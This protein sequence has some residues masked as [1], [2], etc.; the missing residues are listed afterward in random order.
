MVP[1]GE[2]HNSAM[3]HLV[4]FP[5]YTDYVSWVF[6][7]KDVELVRQITT[8][9]A[10][11]PWAEWTP[12]LGFW[13]TYAIVWTF[14]WVGWMALLHERWIEV[15]RL[16]FAFAAT[17]T[18]QINYISPPPDA[19]KTVLRTKLKLFLLGWVLGLLVIFP[20]GL[21]YLFPWIPDPY[22]FASPPFIN[23]YFG[24]LIL[25]TISPINN[26]IPVW[27]AMSLN[28]MHFALF[29]LFPVK[30][31]F[32]I[33]F[34]DVFG[35]KLPS[36]VAYWLGY[37]P[38]GVRGVGAMSGPPFKWA[39]IQV[40]MF[41]GLIVIWF[42]LNIR[43][44]VSTIRL[45]RTPEDSKRALPNPVA[46]IVIAVS[47]I[48]L[49][50]MLGAAGSS[51]TSAILIM[52]VMLYTYLSSIR[53]L[54]YCGPVGT[55][56]MAIDNWPEFPMV[57]RWYYGPNVTLQTVNYEY[58][59]T[60]M[61]TNRFTSQLMSEAN[62]QFGMAFA[63]PLCYKVGFET[64]T[65]PMDLTKVILI[66]AIIS[67]VIG[68]PVGL[69]FD[70]TFGTARTPM[71]MYDAWWI[72]AFPTVGTLYGSPSPDPIIEYLIVGALIT[73][74]CG[75]LNM[76]FI[77]WPLEPAG[78]TLSVNLLGGSVWLLPA[79]AMWVVKVLVLRIG[80]TKLS[81]NY[82]VPLCLGFLVGY[83]FLMFISGLMGMARFFLPA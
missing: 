3:T 79:A 14:F 46:W 75:F 16:P 25:D 77:W 56:W 64:K 58:V 60:M 2:L 43:W 41:I 44:F 8:G 34:F 49:I 83:W 78:V 37:F 73:A 50:A 61:M 31:L 62:T 69:W 72:W 48:I 63:M 51:I 65:H 68:F 26:L 67:A 15:E 29:Y 76:R 45:K 53:I 40:G 17:G 1:Y 36:Q 55:A 5:P 82:V 47:T 4:T 57:F 11:V 59:S 81:D 42:A 18:E 32:S 23:W 52:I 10:P 28:P 80:G 19:D 35:I 38:A 27:W 6:G 24:V 66:A 70:Y 71:G 39:T 33:W 9:G 30:T 7:P 13:I 20:I 54:G 21:H 74:V 22:G 12:W